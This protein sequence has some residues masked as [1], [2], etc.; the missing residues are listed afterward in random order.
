MIMFKNTLLSE[1]MTTDLIT[2]KPDDTLEKAENIFTT[3]DIRHLLVVA[4]DGKVLGIVS[5]SDYLS[6]SDGLAP[7]RS[8]AEQS[9]D[10][11]FLQSLTAQEVMGKQLIK[12][13]PEDKASLAAIIFEQNLF[14]AIPIVGDNDKLL[15]IVTTIDL[16]K[17]AY[18]EPVKVA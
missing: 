16:I 3:K 11:L 2:L 13:G 7:F 8:E 12:L 17:H 14:H 10:L 18:K 9:K 6:I 15:G 1:I 5:K 4:D